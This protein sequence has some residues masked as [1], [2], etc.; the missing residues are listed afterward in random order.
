LRRA[1][2]LDRDGV[3][4]RALV[5]DGKP[6]PPRVIEDL[7]ILPGTE[8]ALRRLRDAGF[9]L[10]VVTNQPDVARG[11]LKQSDLA[12]IHSELQRQLPLDEVL[13]CCHDDAD[14]CTCRKPKPGLL[15]Q[16][17]KEYDLDLS[18]SYMIGDRWRD[19]DAGRN[20]GCVPVL[21]DYQYNEPMSAPPAMRVKSLMQA[22]DWILEHMHRSQG[23]SAIMDLT[24]LK[25]KIF[26][27]GAD[28]ESIMD[29]Y[30]KP[31]IKGFTTNPTLMRKA[32]ITDYSGF[33]QKLL[34]A[35]PDRPVSFEV[36]AD[37][38]ADME[39]Q[40][41]IINTWGE[42][43]YIK[44][45]ITTTAG[46]PAYDL[47]HRLSLAGIKLNITAM[48]TLEQ[49]RETV[50]A[51]IGG[52]SAY[53]SVFAG[54]IADTGRDPIPLMAA[55]VELTTMAPN[56]ELIWASPREVL[57]I[58]Q[59]DQIGCHII[60]V[61]HDLLKKLPGLGKDLGQFSRETVQMFYHDAQASGFQL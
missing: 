50:Q 5:R 39:R 23:E 20:A 30:A 38:F 34:K 54:R 41:H 14:Q 3:L 29:L 11:S 27:D 1:I 28:F 58:F 10:V 47:I 61:T 33:A 21:I 60:T 49:V 24:K 37:D 6:Y 7:D 17:A 57:N 13:T 36:F 25:T 56:S 9:L 43:V 44:I 31:Y 32:G 40:A 8:Q 51:V 46:E 45:P 52:A 35:I 18:K 55:A 12:A 15:Q 26:A 22:T 59:A 48:M 16:T 4:N 53:V 19:I 42:N 2:F